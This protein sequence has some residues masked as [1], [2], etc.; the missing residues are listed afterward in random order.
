MTAPPV[1]RRRIR[2]GGPERRQLLGDAGRLGG[3]RGGGRLRAHP[4]RPDGPAAVPLAAGGGV[5]QCPPASIGTRSKIV[6]RTTIAVI[7]HVPM[8]VGT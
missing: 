1:A 8:Q 7:E 5:I 3:L 2:A 4:A 6:I